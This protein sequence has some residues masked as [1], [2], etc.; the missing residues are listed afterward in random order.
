M[1]T[2]FRIAL[3]VALVVPSYIQAQEQ[4][5]VATVDV[6]AT[7]YGKDVDAAIRNACRAAVEQVVGSMVYAESLVESGEMVSDKIL[8]FSAGYVESHKQ[9]GEPKIT[10]DG[11]VSVRISATIKRRI[12]GEELQKTGINRVFFDGTSLHMKANMQAD[13]QDTAIDLMQQMVDNLHISAL[14]TTLISRD[15][16]INTNRAIFEIETKLDAQKYEA[17]RSAL[18]ELLPAMAGQTV[19]TNQTATLRRANENEVV[20]LLF[21]QTILDNLKQDTYRL[22]I[23]NS[24]PSSLR[25]GQESRASVSFYTVPRVVFNQVTFFFQRKTLVIETLGSND[26]VLNVTKVPSP[27]PY[28]LFFTNQNNWWYVNDRSYPNNTIALLPA[29]RRAPANN[30][31]I[32]SLSPGLPTHRERVTF[33]FPREE[34]DK[35]TSVRF[36]YE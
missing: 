18:V 20:E 11:L 15:Y 22:L 2:I 1:Q 23:F 7:G 26:E 4:D 9:L 24:W 19:V 10:D 6:V 35:I 33:N 21:P 30:N 8:S 32:R 3:I 13:N 27:M 14:S 31:A 36:S 5:S 12:L 34:L 25:A 16:D 17:F 29:I 28:F